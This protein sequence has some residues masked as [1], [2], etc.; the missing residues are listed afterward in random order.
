MSDPPESLA[1]AVTAPAAETPHQRF[2]W[3]VPDKADPW[4]AA[5][6]A[7]LVGMLLSWRPSF[8]FDESATIAAANRSEIDILRL[9]LNFDAVHGL[10]YLAM[11]AWLSWAPINEFT[12]RLP[13]AVAVG[14]AAAGLVVLGKLVANRPTAWAAAVAFAV[15]PRILWSAVEA[16]SYALTAAVAVW[17][18]VVLVIAAAQRGFSLWALYSFVLALA[19]VTY[20]YLGLLV[21]AH[22]VTLMLR[23]KWRQLLPFG[24]AVVAAAALA[25]PLIALAAGQRQTQLWWIGQGGYL[26]GVVWE[27]WL[28]GSRLF[29]CATAVL[30]AWGSIALTTRKAALDALAVALPWMVIPTAILVGYSALGSNVYQPRYLTYTAPGLGL[31]LGVCI[32]AIARQRTRMMLLILAILALSSATA[33]VTQRGRYGKTGGADYSEIARVINANSKPHDCIVFGAADN[34]PL[35]AAA[36]ARPDAFAQ[37]DDVAAGVPG[38][39]AAQLWTQDLPLDSDVVKPRLARCTVLWAIVD[40]TT[41]AP[42]VDAAQRQGFRVDHEQ[43]LNRS[44]VIRLV[45][46]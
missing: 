46:R 11:H 9:L 23:R 12:A 40:R 7:T 30:L 4:I 2:R 15:L 36:A 5:V 25:S 34:E 32:A 27:Q 16:R 14:V 24:V 38:A 33:F 28:T 26:S 20:V 17:L 42:V 22:A 44:K 13:S 1:D 37:L 19:V 41:P 6:L 3:Q 45:K 8:W 21:F 35:R 31:L 43:T 29:M 18:T 10:Y 39:Y